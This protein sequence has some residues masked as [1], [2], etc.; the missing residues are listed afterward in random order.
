MNRH[1]VRT[2]AGVGAAVLLLAAGFL[3]APP[4]SAVSVSPRVL[5]DARKSPEAAAALRERLDRYEAAKALGVDKVYRQFSLDLAKYPRGG[6]AHRNLLVVLAQFPAE[7]S[8]PAL[9]PSKQSTPYYYWKL[10][11]SDDP[12]D[13]I[14]SL[15]EYYENQ[16]H[17]RLIL[18]GQVTSKWVTMPHSYRYYTNGS[19]GLDFTSY[20][21]SGQGL[22]VDA[23][24]A[25][26]GQFGGNL[27]YFDNDGPDG[28]PHSGDDDGY[29]DA[30]LVIHPG[31]GAEVISGIAANDS[32]WSHE[33][34]IP[35]YS[36]C[37]GLTSGPGCQPGLQMGD[38][39]GFLYVLLGEY[40][41]YPGDLAVGTYCHEFGHTLGLPDLYDNTGPSGLGFYS[42]MG[43]G[44][45]LPYETGKVLG[46]HPGG[47]DA[48]CRQFLGFDEP[49]V[50]TTPGHYS[51]KPATEGGGSLR[52]WSN[53]EPGSEYFL[54]ECRKKEGPDQYL[55]ADGLL[56]YHVDDTKVDN[57]SGPPNYR[58]RLV[59]ADSLDP[60][61]LE[62]LPAPYGPG[63]YGDAK[64]SFPGALLKRSW[65]ES[66]QP[67]SR[68][69][70]GMDTGIRVWNIAGGSVDSADS[71]SFDLAIS[72]QPELRVASATIADGG[73]G[74]ADPSETDSIT[75]TLRNVGLPSNALNLTLSTLDAAVTV[76]QQNATGA[77]I[78]GGGIGSNSTP[79]VVSIG[80]IATLPHDILFTLSWSDGASSGTVS[81]T[82]TAGMGAG[83][84]ED[85]ESGAP[86]W[87]HAP[88]APNAIDEWH[89]STSRAHGGSATS[90]KVGSSNPLGVG[91]NEQQN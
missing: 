5:E 76:T 67:N 15:R 42:L 65:T 90:M 63:N 29:I 17:G 80:A 51:L 34:G 28:I 86:G 48:W 89:L 83:L 11:F 85:F 52:V 54:L 44:N 68:D 26:Y 78:A 12:N 64:D 14:I 20:P 58:V 72:S 82:V 73:N 71:A 57:V 19:S 43:L 77:P 35:L 13:G 2:G 55:P 33:A 69:Y 23:M 41:E 10:L 61:D 84:A 25:A 16:S 46:S 6:V 47:L 21:R 9:Y 87:T 27:E 88:V 22:V 49:D 7:G 75:V 66:T 8:A 37:D 40:N 50:V 59:P 62:T 4:A 3:A 1:R 79:F 70:A 31:R 18:S 38:V 74:Y 91:T 24:R 39:K 53:G 32:L 81:F 56:I 60:L 45:Y 36:G 30:T